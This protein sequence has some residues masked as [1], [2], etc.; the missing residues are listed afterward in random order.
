LV[1]ARHA[2]PGSVR[3]ANPSSPESPQDHSPRPCRS[4]RGHRT[5]RRSSPRAKQHRQIF[6]PDDAVKVAIAGRALARVE[7][8]IAIN[9]RSAARDFDRVVDRVRVAVVVARIGPT[10]GVRV[11]FKSTRNVARI[12]N[13]VRVAIEEAE[14][15]A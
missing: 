13:A 4:G 6:R 8:T 15:P 10:V 7:A 5:E 3:A 11:E 2:E 1:K 9:I 12:R 14:A